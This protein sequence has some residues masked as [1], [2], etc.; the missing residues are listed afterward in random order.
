MTDFDIAG[1]DQDFAAAN[2][3]LSVAVERLRLL[4]TVQPEPR[5]ICVLANELWQSWPANGLASVLAATIVKLE[6]AK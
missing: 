5:A 4:R 1:Y 3:C 6:E 2:D